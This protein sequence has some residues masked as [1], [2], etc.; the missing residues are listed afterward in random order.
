MPTVVFISVGGTSGRAKGEGKGSEHDCETLQER[1]S[2]GTSGH[3]LGL[4]RRSPNGKLRQADSVQI[5]DP[6][7][8]R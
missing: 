5:A 2:S 1:A 7:H 3:R 4:S 8:A 6:V